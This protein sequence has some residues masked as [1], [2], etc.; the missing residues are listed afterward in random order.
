M[1]S[2]H[3]RN[4]EGRRQPWL[5]WTLLTTAVALLVW[6]ALAWWEWSAW[7]GELDPREAAQ[8]VEVDR[9]DPSSQP[10]GVVDRQRQLVGE[11][12]DA[13]GPNLDG[14]PDQSVVMGRI[15]D[16]VTGYGVQGALI[17]FDS[18]GEAGVVSGRDGRFVLPWGARSG[19]R[20]MEVRARGYMTLRLDHVE[21]DREIDL[22]VRR[23]SSVVLQILAMGEAPGGAVPCG[24]VEC[25]LRRPQGEPESEVA[26]SDANGLVVVECPCPWKGPIHLS[27][28]DGTQ[29]DRLLSVPTLYGGEPIVI[30]LPRPTVLNVRVTDSADRGIGFAAVEWSPF[31]DSRAI[32][33]ADGRLVVVARLAVGQPLSVIASADG[34]A[35]RMVRVIGTDSVAR[36]TG[37]RL[38]AAAHLRLQVEETLLAAG[39][40]LIVETAD[41]W[42][43]FYRWSARLPVESEM[44]VH[45]VVAGEALQVGVVVAGEYQLLA[46]VPPIEPGKT[47][48]CGALDLAPAWN[49]TI[50]SYGGRAT[51][52]WKLWGETP[53]RG[54]LLRE[55]RVRS[56]ADGVA[57]LSGRSGDRLE[58]F[59]IVGT[60]AGSSQSVVVSAGAQADVA[61]PP[62]AEV[63]G[64]VVGGDGSRAIVVFAS[65]AGGLAVVTTCDGAGK[66]RA[67]G[68]DEGQEYSVM[69]FGVEG[70]KLSEPSRIVARSASQLMLSLEL[71]TREPLRKR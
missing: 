16:E 68:L 49:V 21:L 57:T 17:Y 58:V 31:V 19:V 61:L 43:R 69:V 18:G 70:M 15:I 10:A 11:S 47:H 1:N 9:G 54:F 62:V 55:G 25:H 40:T 45:D 50:G 3:Q 27:L 42:S 66:F 24:D 38:V 53:G 52:G 34:F 26:R 35:P 13:S 37:I 67:V 44:V 48:D 46:M 23:V 39:G 14:L 63:S 8:I 41:S 7:R 2:D 29:F 30:V 32:A 65:F 60:T 22:A 4:G 28:R 71:R 51:I 5:L 56:D 20:R 64:W 36:E 33:D 6:F 59:R 12:E